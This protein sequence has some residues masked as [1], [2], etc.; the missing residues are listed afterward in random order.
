MSIS[1]DSPDPVRALYRL[2]SRL[3]LTAPEGRAL[4]GLAMAGLLGVGAHEWQ[5]SSGLPSADLYTEADAA[6]AAASRSAPAAA[7]MLLPAPGEP[8]PALALDTTR[9]PLPAPPTESDLTEAD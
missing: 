8:A 2:Q 4:L 1:R 3:G 7:Q 5:Q 6:F 9:A